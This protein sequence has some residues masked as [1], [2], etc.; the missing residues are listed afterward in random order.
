MLL[1]AGLQA[2][3]AFEPQ[4]VGRAGVAMRVE[5]SSASY[6]LDAVSWSELLHQFELRR[7]EALTARGSHALTEVNLGLQ[8]S[9]DTESELCGI[10]DGVLVLR[11]REHLPKWQPRE[12]VSLEMQAN[13]TA[14]RDGL[15]TH[16]AGHQ[17]VARETAQRLVNALSELGTAAE[18]RDLLRQVES[19]WLREWTRMEI[20]QHAYDR[21]TD[22]G[23]R[24]GAVLMVD[25]GIQSWRAKR[26]RMHRGG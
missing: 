8:Y 21:R 9:L 2:E 10:R 6:V 11:I 12:P 13:W 20:R 15:D 22:R 5:Y 4:P 19:I 7:P 25:R 23:V 18:C 16:E 3:G 17:Q 24:Q 1:S 26:D 14:M